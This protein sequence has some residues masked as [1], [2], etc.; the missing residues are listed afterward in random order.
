[1]RRSRREPRRGPRSPDATRHGLE[2]V[3]YLLKWL[4]VGVMVVAVAVWLL[5][6]GS[7]EQASQPARLAQAVAGDLV[8]L[9]I[10]YLAVSLLLDSRDLG[11]DSRLKHEL[12]QAIARR[13]RRVPE[14]EA[15]Y[16]RIT[17]TPY[18][19]IFAEAS[20]LELVGRW[21]NET[22]SRHP[23]ELRQFF[24]Q[25]GDITLVVMD[26]DNEHCVEQA[27]YQYGGYRRDMEAFRSQVRSK[28]HATIQELRLACLDA[29]VAPED[30]LDIWIHSSP[31]NY[32]GIR[33]RS[34]ERDSLLLAPYDNFRRQALACPT[35]VFDLLQGRSSREFW[36]AEVEFF[37]AR[38][39]RW[40]E[41]ARQRARAALREMAAAPRTGD[42]DS[43]ETELE[44]EEVTDLLIDIGA[45]LSGDVFHLPTENSDQTLLV[46]LQ[47][48]PEYGTLLTAQVRVDDRDASG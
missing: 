26:P 15:T 30:H 29:G 36:T 22:F 23:D 21:Y 16:A 24:Q 25:G 10:A 45:S 48:G 44:L 41:W 33:A 12:V 2:A 40:D 34:S 39:V 28:A 32:W 5:V 38:S 42:I 47:E 17:D 6:D 4:A 27:A 14:V 18:G 13:V 46:T 37:K 31:M 20:Q 35:V 8:T 43:L 1:M 9:S 19:E 7:P 3:D 11:P